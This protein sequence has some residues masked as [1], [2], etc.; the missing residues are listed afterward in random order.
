MFFFQY[1][2]D[3]KSI[4]GETHCNPVPVMLNEHEDGRECVEMME[5]AMEEKHP[6]NMQLY[7]EGYAELLSQ[8]IYKEDNILYPMAEDALK[9]EV[10]Q[11]IAKEYA[12]VEKK[13]DSKFFEKYEKFLKE[14]EKMTASKKPKKQ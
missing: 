3:P 10:K 12:E 8:H 2:V 14:V 4:C 6:D 9:E 7:C 13:Y 5:H 1:F 11:K